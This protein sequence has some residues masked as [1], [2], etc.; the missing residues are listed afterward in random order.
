VATSSLPYR[1]WDAA[2][3]A[4]GRIHS[5]HPD[6]RIVLG[7]DAASRGAAVGGLPYQSLPRLDGE[8]FDGLLAE[9]PVCVVLYPSGRPPWV[10]DLMAAGC[11]VIAVASCLG[12]HHV[13][14]ESVE[15]VIGA[16]AE[17]D[18]I[19]EAIDSLLIDRIRLTALT[20]RAADRVGDMP[21]A[22]EAARALLRAFDAA[23][24][25]TVSNHHAE[26]QSSCSP[27]ARV[28]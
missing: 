13:V 21:D 22:G 18:A 26:G 11:P 1:A 2:V 28:A 8:E 10:N 23:G 12:H 5:D 6:V 20:S 4:L 25:P 3:A 14:S 9:R 16:Y 17:A 19:T 24:E 27:V 7:G 15:G